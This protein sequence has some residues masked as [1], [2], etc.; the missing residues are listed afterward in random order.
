MWDVVFGMSDV[1]FGMPMEGKDRSLMVAAPSGLRRTERLK[2]AEMK[3]LFICL[4]AV[5]RVL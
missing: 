5:G 2:V 3:R 1:A 4:R